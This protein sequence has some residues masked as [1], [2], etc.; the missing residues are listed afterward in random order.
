MKNHDI[1]FASRP[2]TTMI[3]KLFYDSKDVLCAPY[4]EY[5]RQMR[6]ICVLHLLSKK[7]VQSF[8]IVR[9]EEISI[10]MEKIL[11]SSSLPVDLSGMFLRLANDMICRVALGRTYSGGEGASKIRRL[12]GELVE[13]IGRFSVGDHIPWLA[14]VDHVNGI[15]AKADRLAK[16]FDEFIDGVIEEHL[17]SKEKERNSDSIDDDCK[18]LVDVLLQIQKDS[19]SGFSINRESIKALILVSIC[20]YL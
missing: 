16:E 8:D 13:L 19:N 10:L 18:D 4:G 20:V 2:K 6:S 7:R 14:W 1:I 5:W 17:D 9:G 3:K 15:N 11:E 12:L